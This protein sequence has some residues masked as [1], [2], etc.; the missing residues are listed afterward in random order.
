[1]S[2][3]KLFHTFMLLLFASLTFVIYLDQ[4]N[5]LAVKGQLRL[6]NYQTYMTA[7]TQWPNNG[8]E[9]YSLIQ[10]HTKLQFFQFIHATESSLNLTE[11]TL[12]KQS[13]NPLDDLLDRK[14]VV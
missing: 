7:N 10:N 14:S 13:A 3:S 12:S 1:M 11:G 6:S 9:L 2:V 8:T 5:Q 4:N